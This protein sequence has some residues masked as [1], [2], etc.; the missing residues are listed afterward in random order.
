MP[1]LL[2]FRGLRYTPAAGKIGD[3]LAPPYDVI[4]PAQQR[5]LEIQSPCNAVRLE[6]A[7]GGSERY[8]DVASLL[9]H[10][11]ADGV[12]ARDAAPMLYI[13]EQTFFEAGREHTRR[14]LI[15]AVE[16]QPWDE[17]A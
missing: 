1:Q 15:A 17:G 7:D 12:L 16:A 10:W 6:L 14:G 11:R 4:S 8:E 3:L 2:P 5:A 9:E 13:Y